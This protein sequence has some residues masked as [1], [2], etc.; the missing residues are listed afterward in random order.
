MKILLG[1]T[2]SVATIKVPL[3]L[4]GL[5]DRFENCQIRLIPTEKAL[6][7]LKDSAEIP[8]PIYRDQDEWDSWQ[9]RGDPVLHIELRK[10]ADVLLIAPLDA[11]TLAKISNGLADNLLTCVARAWD[12]A[13]PCLVAPAMNTLMWEH[14]VTKEQLDRL[15]KWGFVE[16]PCVEKV[17][18]C[19]DKG[20]G[21]MAEPG[22]II[23][24]VARVSLQASS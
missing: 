10:W 16:I 22:T 19:N 1:V 7:F 15:K 23:D 13:K 2:G 6:H 14:P 4:D 24:Y 12:F 20:L 18:M 11:N 21:A 9:G 17:L 8:A 5:R 3:I